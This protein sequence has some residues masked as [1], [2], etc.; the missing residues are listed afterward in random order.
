MCHYNLSGENSE[1]MES[2]GEDCGTA[3][4]IS[5]FCSGSN[6]IGVTRAM[7]THCTFD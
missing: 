7:C 6:L 3:Q 2:N 1:A 5:H 4:I